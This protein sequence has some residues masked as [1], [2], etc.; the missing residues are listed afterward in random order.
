MAE[1]TSQQEGVLITFTLLENGRVIIN[2]RSN[3]IIITPHQTR[4][5]YRWLRRRSLWVFVILS[6][7]LAGSR[8]KEILDWI[9]TIGNFLK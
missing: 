8:Y 3:G 7:L 2:T 5:A 9:D 1:N 4:K 6:T